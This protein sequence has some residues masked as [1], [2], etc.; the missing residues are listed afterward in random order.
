MFPPDVCSDG[1]FFLQMPM[2]GNSG[3]NMSKV[4]PASVIK[5]QPVE[6]ERVSSP[7]MLV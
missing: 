4:H 1:Y 5:E 2:A 6:R 3:G 7:P